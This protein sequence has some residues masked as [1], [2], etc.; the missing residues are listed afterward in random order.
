[1]S[2]AFVASASCNAW[3]VRLAQFFRSRSKLGDMCCV[4]QRAR[5]S[6]EDCFPCFACPA[7]PPGSR[8]PRFAGVARGA[9][10]VREHPWTLRSRPGAVAPACVYVR[11]VP[12]DRNQLQ[13]KTLSRSF[14]PRSLLPLPIRVFPPRPS[15]PSI[16]KFE[17]RGSRFQFFWPS[18]ALLSPRL[19]AARKT[20]A[21]GPREGPGIVFLSYVG[22]RCPA[23]V[24][25]S[26]RGVDTRSEAEGPT[27]ADRGIMEG[28]G[29]G[30][31]GGGRGRGA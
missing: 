4:R 20:G 30:R 27:R 19:E 6:C 9:V 10:L 15:C 14:P 25:S 18:G 31:T 29:L 23:A 22:R 21:F 8:S 3:P 16:S 28:K 17:P 1:M 2:L 5:L 13:K 24:V 11:L 7:G 12:L 26:E